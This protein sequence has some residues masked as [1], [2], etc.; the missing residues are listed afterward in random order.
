MTLVES[1]LPVS[2][3]GAPATVDDRVAAESLAGDRDG[4]SASPEFG[5]PRIVID[6]RVGVVLGA[7][8]P[9]LAVVI[10]SLPLSTPAGMCSLIWVAEVTGSRGGARPEAADG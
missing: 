10:V 9:P 8:V 4:V 2:A 1:W 7:V 5:K 6:D 3:A